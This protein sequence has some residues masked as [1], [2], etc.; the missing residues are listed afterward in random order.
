MHFFVEIT[1]ENIVLEFLK[2]MKVLK[3]VFIDSHKPCEKIQTA[4]L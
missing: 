2:K 1:L 4:A 3:Y